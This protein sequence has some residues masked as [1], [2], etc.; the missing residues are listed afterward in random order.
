MSVIH[1]IGGDDREL[2]LSES[3]KSKG[4]TLRL[5]GFE[6]KGFDKFNLETINKAIKPSDQILFP[7]SGTNEHGVV[8]GKYSKVPIVIDESFFLQLPNNTTICIGWAR[9]WF[10]DLAQKYRCAVK[11]VANDDELAILNSIPSAEGA[12]QMA[13]EN[14]EITIHGSKVLVIGFGRCGITLARKLYG[15]G[16][17]ITIVTRNPVNLAR[18]FEMGF[19]SIH[20]NQANSYYNNAEIIFNTAPTMVLTK[21]ELDLLKKVE[22]IIDI[23]SSPGGVD[24]AYSKKI[25]VKALLAPGLP[26]VIAPKTAGKMLGKVLP[27]FLKEEI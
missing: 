25:G 1:L 24:F 19:E 9:Q 10:L 26:G 18:A 6:N 13:I 23:A 12:I 3:L 14:S 4:Y 22:V 5:W 8:K 21:N 2:Y 7:M 27:K 11:Q 20:P 16:A 17:K 15:L